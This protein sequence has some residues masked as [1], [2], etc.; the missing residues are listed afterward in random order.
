MSLV[1]ALFVF[2]FKWRSLI[3]FL[4]NIFFSTKRSKFSTKN[5]MTKKEALEILGLNEGASKKEIIDSYHT[6]LK[7]NHPDLGG[8]DWITSQ[9]NKA[10]ETLLG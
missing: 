7:K 8:S 9:L 1:P 10:K 2:L 4:R 3:F 5:I 6:L